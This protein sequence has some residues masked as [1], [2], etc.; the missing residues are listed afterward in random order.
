MQS[1]IFL[2]FEKKYLS[3]NERCYPMNSPKFFTLILSIS[4]FFFSCSNNAPEKNK[5]Q[6]MPANTV[7]HI[8]FNLE[9]LS[10]KVDFEKVITE[11]M[12]LFIMDLPEQ[13]DNID[14]LRHFIENPSETGIDVSK[15]IDFFFIKEEEEIIPIGILNLLD[16]KKLK[17][18]NSEKAKDYSNY[19]VY[20]NHGSLIAWNKN[21]LIGTVL[22]DETGIDDEIN[23]NSPQMK[24]INRIFSE[25]MT[26]TLY[27][28]ENFKEYLKTDEDIKVWLSDK[29]LSNMVKTAISYQL[30]VSL[31]SIYLNA[32]TNFEEHEILF[33]VKILAGTMTQENVLTRLFRPATEA[34][35]INY[36]SY[37]STSL[38]FA[39]HVDKAGLKKM[40]DSY[41]IFAN[42][43]NRLFNTMNYSLIDIADQLNGDLVIGISNFFPSSGEGNYTLEENLMENP[44]YVLISK[45]INPDFFIN[46]HKNVPFIHKTI[47]K[48]LFEVNNDA[49]IFYYKLLDSIIILSN[50]MNIINYANN[51]HDSA[52]TNNN[53]YWDTFRNYQFFWGLNFNRPETLQFLFSNQNLRRTS[54]DDMAYLESDKMIF[55]SFENMILGYKDDL[56]FEYKLILP[57]KYNHSMEL[58][59]ELILKNLPSLIE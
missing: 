59:T 49:N 45:A 42:M 44:D 30:G 38:T 33:N 29:V 56:T 37:D 27:D 36:L 26:S 1:G 53:A 22:P 55:S 39:A 12:N 47:E 57:Q 25:D 24:L 18:F 15:E 14:Q 4:L 40:V 50:N 9:S 8:S 19:S 16:N 2:T 5:Y 54:E 51:V 21:Y 35:I 10:E 23:E 6:M 34:D 3:Y 43:N 32:S 41:E 13:A 52:H 20:Q 31:D 46:L 7:G 48:G 11:L 28:N 17:F 58:V